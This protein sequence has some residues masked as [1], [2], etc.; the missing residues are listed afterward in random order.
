M[1]FSPLPP[2]SVPTDND[3]NKEDGCSSHF[4]KTDWWL[5][6]ADKDFEGKRLAVAGLTSRGQ[7]Q[8]RVF[9]SAP[10][11]RRFDI[12]TLET[13]DGIYVMIQGLLNKLR[14]VENGFSSEA[15]SHFLFGFPMYW[16]EYA[17]KY[18]R[19]E[20]SKGIG[21]RNIS[22]AENATTK[23]AR[24]SRSVEE[25]R[26]S[27]DS[28]FSDG[29]LEGTEQPTGSENRS[30][31]K[32][33]E[34]DRNAT[35]RTM[36]VRMMQSRID[37]DNDNP[38]A[39]E[40]DALNVTPPSN[41]GG[42]RSSIELNYSGRKQKENP[43]S[44]C[45]MNDK[46]N[47]FCGVNRS[48][49]A[50]VCLGA[51][52]GSMSRS[53]AVGD[54]NI[55]EFS[56]NHNFN[57]TMAVPMVRSTIDLNSNSPNAVEIDAVNFT[58]AN[59]NGKRRVIKGNY[60]RRKQRE[61]P[62]SRC[63]MKDKDK[64][65]VRE[66]VELPDEKRPKGNSSQSAVRSRVKIKASEATFS[67]SVRQRSRNLL[68]TPKSKGKLRTPNSKGRKQHSSANKSKRKIVFD[69]H[70]S[71]LTQE[72]EVCIVSPE[73]LSS[74]RSRSGRLVVP[75]LQF[76]RNQIPIYDVDRNMIGIQEDKHVLKPSRGF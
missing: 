21:L 59:S 31:D 71:P 3:G 54:F 33:K 50:D 76:W 5:I 30:R 11:T 29:N 28:K 10:I 37:G 62:V 32:E 53:P 41:Y 23:P 12:F 52:C 60:L 27:V 2:Q 14:T 74:K 17:K 56:E 19:E 4:L 40:M 16:E 15:S 63:S 49:N 20:P 51:T 46:D 43:V 73:S 48:N 39:V 55:P 18:F 24:F 8:M 25:V 22:T 47:N 7:Q 67:Q 68:G 57:T 72:R 34:D 9:Y 66:E 75:P 64:M 1:A 65:Y 38:N 26:V 58:P 44:T 45:C 61:N 36:S 42:K 35:D 69:A 13:A 6:K 70:V